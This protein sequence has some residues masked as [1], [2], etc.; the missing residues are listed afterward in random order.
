MA[1]VSWVVVRRRRASGMS[2]AAL[3]EIVDSACF[4]VDTA[5]ERLSG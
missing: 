4:L 5:E 3:L 2:G 1:E